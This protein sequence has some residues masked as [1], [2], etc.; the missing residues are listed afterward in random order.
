MLFGVRV[1]RGVSGF[2]S[3]T[4]SDLHNIL[5]GSGVGILQISR[6]FRLIVGIGI[7]L[8]QF[9]AWGALAYSWATQVTMQL[10]IYAMYGRSRRTL[11]MMVTSFLCE[12]VAIAF[13][14]WRTI[15]PDSSLKGPFNPSFPDSLPGSR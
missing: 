3:I 13:I 14:I 5:S 2:V 4:T 15:G 11:V 10:R 7:R 1:G 8:F 12:V 6:S 9:R